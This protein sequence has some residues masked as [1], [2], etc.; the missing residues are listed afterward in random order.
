MN[1]RCFLTKG[2]TGT[3]AG[4]LPLKENWPWMTSVLRV[5][6]DG[7]QGTALPTLPLLCSKK[8]MMFL[9]LRWLSILEVNHQGDR[10][11]TP[12]YRLSRLPRLQFRKLLSP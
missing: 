11:I 8:V 2:R 10:T 3:G 5:K 1:C 12:S 9:M 6:G 4:T 7:R